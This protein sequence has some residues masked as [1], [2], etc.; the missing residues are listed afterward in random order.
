MR[1]AV[2][3]LLCAWPIATIVVSAAFRMHPGRLDAPEVASW[4]AVAGS[5]TALL[6]LLLVVI[7]FAFF[8]AHQRVLAEID[9]F[10]DLDRE[11]ARHVRDLQ[12][13]VDFLSA[14]REANLVIN[15]DVET[16]ALLTKLLEIASYLVG[17]RDGD[18][19]T[20]H[21]W[22]VRAASLIPVAQRAGRETRFGKALAQAASS[23]RRDVQQAYKEGRLLD[24][25][26]AS[27]RIRLVM[28]M[29][30]NRQIVG[31]LEVETVLDG[32]PDERAERRE[33]LRSQLPEFASCLAVGLKTKDLYTRTIQDGLTGLYSKRHF[34]CEV[35]KAFDEARR[36]GTPLA[37]VMVDIDHFKSINDTHG[38]PTGDVVLKEV[39]KIVREGVRSYT[40]AF[41]YGGEE[42]AILF[43]RANAE[44]ASV[45]AERLRRKIEAK[46]F[47]SEK[48]VPFKV[49]AS[50]GV[51][52]HEGVA[53]PEELVQRADEALYAAKQG[54][55]NQVRIWTSEAAACRKET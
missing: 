32:G 28:P 4:A 15:Q 49:T 20:V 47:S 13:R 7:L 36:E 29:S 46:R 37:L 21:E 40:Y 9:S 26:D 11:R 22:D 19:I 51:A 6:A 33:R 38:H 14:V 10:R 34:L 41:R 42:I 2:A 1:T 18:V 54:G 24:E 17:N 44:K 5:V 48:G 27:G 30:T 16:E 12:G 43:T 55:R 8:R 3:V 39:A 50:F 23:D 31:A 35:R 53:T 25:Q 52:E 45:A